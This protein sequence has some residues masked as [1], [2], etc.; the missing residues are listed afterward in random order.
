MQPGEHAARRPEATALIEPAAPDG[1][2]ERRVSYAELDA[3]S[4]QLAQLLRA[5]GLRAGDRI[6]ILLPNC[7]EYLEVAWAAQR[8][9]LYYVPINWH[10]TAEEAAYILHDSDAATLVTSAHLAE[11]LT[12]LRD[13]LSGVAHRF[14]LHGPLSGYEQLEP[15]MAEQPAAPVA[16]EQEGAW[17]FYSSGT[18][19]RP[20]GIKPNTI[21]APPGTGTRLN[22]LLDLMYGFDEQTVYLCPAPLYHA[23][24]LGWSVSTTRL[25]GAVVIMPRFDAEEALRLI[26]RYRVTHAQ[27]VP[28]HFVRMLKLPAEVRERYDLS[29]LRL[30]V[31]AA[32][33]CPPEVKRQM[34]EWWGP[35]IHEYYAG[36]EGIGFCAIGPEEWLAHPGSVGRPVAGA[37]H[38]LDE[39]GS[40][41]PAGEP[42]Q[43]WF[44]TEQTFEY[45]KDP[46]KTAAAWNE[47][48]WATLGDIGYVDAEGFL[49]LTDRA[50]N[51]IISG[52]ANIYPREVEDVLVVHPEVTDVAVIGIPDEDMGEQ[53][54]AVVQLA[55]PAA[56]DDEKARELIDYTRARLAHYKCPRSV[57]FVDEL[58]RTPTG[59]LRKHE[60]AAQLC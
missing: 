20:K 31:H 40:E 6:A 46:E 54:R 3:R 45:H 43:V 1:S 11:L 7:A 28:T 57:A 32:A 18:T 17:M 12:A 22:Q 36:S 13:E 16:D 23:A 55:D 4:N 44:E 58:P 42:G 34:L 52:G 14:V 30:A 47:K 35:I 50:T 41:L 8:S 59:K 25:G 21:G 39:E 56:G 49:Y 5:R 15:L 10:L 38:I 19:G 53:V 29:S 33:P 9:G 37:V 27:F 2:G 24:P 48:G 60:L 51:L 26:E